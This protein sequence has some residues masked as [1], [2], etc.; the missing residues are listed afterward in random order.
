MRKQRVVHTKWSRSVLFLWSCS[1][2]NMS[3]PSIRWGINITSGGV[4]GGEGCSRG[5]HSYLT[6][7]KNP[8]PWSN[9]FV[10]NVGGGKQKSIPAYGC[11]VNSFLR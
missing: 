10:K 6:Q 11:K 5:V 8:A 9:T 4:G 1:C 2:M 7:E 3:I